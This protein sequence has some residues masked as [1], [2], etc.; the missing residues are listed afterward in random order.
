M[1]KFMIIICIVKCNIVIVNVGLI[2]TDITILLFLYP[3]GMIN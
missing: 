3:E 2:N 1:C